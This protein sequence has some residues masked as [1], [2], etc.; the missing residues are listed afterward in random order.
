MDTQRLTRRIPGTH[1][2]AP[3]TD[4]LTVTITEV[5]EITVT[6]PD[7]LILHGWR[8]ARADPQAVAALG[9][10][11]P[12]TMTESLAMALLLAADGED[13][14]A[15]LAERAPTLGLRLTASSVLATR[16]SDDATIYEAIDIVDA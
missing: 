5:R 13:S 3:D 9:Y 16:T 6:A 4:P 1:T 7:A 8:I 2:N 14:A 12:W 10:A 11:H 15:D